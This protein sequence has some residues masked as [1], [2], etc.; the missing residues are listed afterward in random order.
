MASAVIAEVNMF[1]DSRR[2]G[3]C[4]DFNGTT[5]LP[6]TIEFV[7]I[8]CKAPKEN[9]VNTHAIIRERPAIRARLNA[10]VSGDT[11][12]DRPENNEIKE[13]TS[14]SPSGSS[15]KPRPLSVLILSIDSISRLN[16]IRAMPKTAQHLYDNNWFELQGYNKV[17]GYVTHTYSRE[18]VA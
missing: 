9:Y 16:L 6:A 1:L 3:H 18:R 7:L 5:I 15:K 4:I 8:R 2:L 17:S 13:S 11:P 12:A 10:M 14:S